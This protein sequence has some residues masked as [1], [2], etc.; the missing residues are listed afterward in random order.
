[1]TERI[2]ERRKMI[3]SLV[4]H[5][6]IRTATP[7]GSKRLVEQFGLEMSSATVRAELAALTELGFLKQAH[8]SGG[9]FPT[10]RGYRYFVSEL[11]QIGELS[12]ERRRMI[13]HQFYQMQSEQGVDGWMKLSA[14]ILATTSGAISLVS[15]PY[16]QN[17]AV[18]HIAL[19]SLSDRQI[20][21]IVVTNSGQAQQRLISIDSVTTQ[22]QLT[23]IENELNDLLTGLNSV[24]IREKLT[25]NV[26]L[27]E[28]ALKS[29]LTDHVVAAMS[30]VET[31]ETG[32]IYVDGLRSAIQE[33]EFTES[34]EARG[35]LKLLEEKIALRAILTKTNAETRPGGIQVLIGGEGSIENLNHCSLVL[36]R[37]GK[38]DAIGGMIGI[39][40]PMRMRYA[41]NIPMVRFVAGILSD[42]V[43]EA[44][45]SEK[46]GEE[47]LIPIHE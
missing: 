11:M 4:V 47:K 9:R 46:N 44:F 31:S 35:A 2:S 30:E 25:R 19:I 33:P 8:I 32:E 14:S 20:L 38:S 45:A 39:L 13:E 27:R 6:Y 21:M 36:G 34:G 43:G 22:P 5:D 3:L 29:L 42:L 16:S 7:I 37:Y 17:L 18:K 1:M 24:R 41:R 23:T 10:E 12:E 26:S 28:S 15:A 40:G